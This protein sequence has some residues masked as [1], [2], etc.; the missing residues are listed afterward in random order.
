MKQNSL[1]QQHLIQ[2]SNQGAFNAH[3]HKDLFYLFMQ[4]SCG[5]KQILAVELCARI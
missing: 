4:G 3:K 2:E 5:G 1:S